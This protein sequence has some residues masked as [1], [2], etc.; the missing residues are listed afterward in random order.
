MREEKNVTAVKKCKVSPGQIRD[1]LN[2]MQAVVCLAA[3][4]NL[5]LRDLQILME[6]VIRLLGR[7]EAISR[8]TILN[9]S[10][11]D[12]GVNPL[13]VRN[14]EMLHHDAMFA[15]VDIEYIS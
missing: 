12:E 5:E 15:L 6:A 2:E 8:E 3:K 14:L 13:L 1:M 9:L 7:Y 10:L 11:M 4:K